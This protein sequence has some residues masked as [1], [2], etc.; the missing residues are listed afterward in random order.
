MNKYTEHI[1]YQT[2]Y[3]KSNNEETIKGYLY[4][5]AF[6]KQLLL[7]PCMSVIRTHLDRPL[8]RTATHS[9]LDQTLIQTFYKKNT[10]M[11]F[12]RTKICEILM[13]I[14]NIMQ[15]VK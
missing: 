8:H 13:Q 2:I 9:N 12:E 11:F 3:H 10:K 7:A 4:S 6:Y 14:R 1:L 5:H 15:I